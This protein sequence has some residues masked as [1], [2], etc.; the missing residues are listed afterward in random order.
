[1]SGG[2]GSGFRSDQFDLVRLSGHE[3]DYVGL[4]IGSSKIRLFWILDYIGMGQIGYIV[5]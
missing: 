3:S 5:I 1:M 4:D 2:F